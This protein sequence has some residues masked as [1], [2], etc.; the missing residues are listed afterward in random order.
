MQDKK[1]EGEKKIPESPE[2]FTCPWPICHICSSI[3]KST[4]IRAKSR[5]DGPMSRLD[6]PWIHEYIRRETIRLD[7]DGGGGRHMNGDRDG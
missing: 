5:T 4:L 1:R 2:E 7:G 6:G 3:T